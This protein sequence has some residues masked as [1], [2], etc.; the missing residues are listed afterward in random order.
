MTNEIV[1][2]SKATDVDR[3]AD[4]SGNGDLNPACGSVL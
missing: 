3:R 2:G 1:C 4:R